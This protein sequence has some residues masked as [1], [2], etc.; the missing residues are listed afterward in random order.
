MWIPPRRTWRGAK[1]STKAA[2]NQAL[3]AVF[4]VS[5]KTTLAGYLQL[6]FTSGYEYCQSQAD[7]SKVDYGKLFIS[8]VVAVALRFA[9]DH[10]VSNSPTPLPEGHEV[11]PNA[12]RVEPLVKG[13]SSVSSNI[14]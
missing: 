10:N 12:A 13:S 2:A 6:A 11:D 7:P 14:K 8:A 4:G 3:V 9:K 1:V 5:W